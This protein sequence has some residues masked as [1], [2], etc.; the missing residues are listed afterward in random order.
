VSLIGVRRADLASSAALR[1]RERRRRRAGQINS[2]A[3]GELI[4]REEWVGCG[5][6]DARGLDPCGGGAEQRRREEE[7]P[8]GVEARRGGYPEGWG[9]ARRAE[10]WGVCGL[11]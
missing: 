6:G 9:R 1:Q 5:E 7:A 11:K 10:G 3:A 8:G 2:G 4:P